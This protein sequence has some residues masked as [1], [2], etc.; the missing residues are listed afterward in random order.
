MGVVLVDAC[1]SRS[2]WRQSSQRISP[3]PCD[4]LAEADHKSGCKLACNMDERR[5]LRSP[6]Q[7]PCHPHLGESPCC[8]AIWLHVCK[9]VTVL[10]EGGRG[11]AQFVSKLL[12]HHS[13][14]YF[15]QLSLGAV[16]KDYITGTVLELF[17]AAVILTKD[18][19]CD[20]CTVIFWQLGLLGESISGA[21]A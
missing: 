18:F 10:T 4:P 19:E 15:G 8:F 5:C 14:L 13:T 17:L 16:K 7:H 20:V 12:P 21:V 11:S 2:C 1:E 6:T 9:W 3:T